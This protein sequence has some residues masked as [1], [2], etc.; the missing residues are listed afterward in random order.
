MVIL[1]LS[2]HSHCCYQGS[3]PVHQQEEEG[4][5]GEE[6]EEGEKEKE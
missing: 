4:K 6:E 3:Q 5:K 2:S 1:F